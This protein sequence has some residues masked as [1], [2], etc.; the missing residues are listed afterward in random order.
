MNLSA[1]VFSADTGRLE[2]EIGSGT[3]YFFLRGPGEGIVDVQ[4]DTFS[5][6]LSG[7]TDRSTVIVKSKVG[8]GTLSSLNASELRRFVAK[9][10]TVEDGILDFQGGVQRLV[11][12]NA[13]RSQINVGGAET[14]K[15]QLVIS[16]GHAT[17]TSVFSNRAI[18]FGRAKSMI[19]A[20][21]DVDLVQA[22]A[23]AKFRTKGPMDAQIEGTSWIASLPTGVQRKILWYADH[24]EG[25]LVDWDLGGGPNA[26]GG[27]FNTGGDQVE[28]SASDDVAHSGRFSAKARI[29]GAFQSQN[30]NR[31]VRLMRWTNK[32][33]DQGGDF[34]RSPAYYSTWMYIPEAYDPGKDAPWDPGDGGWW[35]VFQFKS[36][37]ANGVSQPMFSMNIEMNE[38]GQMVPYLWSAQEEKSYAP[39]TE[40]A[41]TPG[42]WV[43][44]EAYYKS[45]PNNNG[46]ITLYQDGEQI[47]DVKNVQ[48][49]LPGGDEAAVWG[50]G[51]YTDHIDGGAVDGEA[52][53]YFDDSVVSTT[54]ISKYVQA[55]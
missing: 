49:V 22:P 21:G 47:I 7:T 20:D 10:I 24:E 46:R 43:H 42:K 17:D 27:I 52:T 48:T 55:P 38:D 30:G 14:L 53:I 25:S 8:T 15:N 19:D 39:K 26:G 4:G 12:G 41:I 32:P 5:L 45:S 34:F 18:K 40:I 51:N 33:W 29:T 31:A 13:N 2:L 16:I 28:A 6:N 23:I 37:D 35:N 36:D 11:I 3:A 50:I 9:S 54:R 44:I 1:S